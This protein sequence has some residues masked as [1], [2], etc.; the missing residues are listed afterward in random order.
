MYYED[1]SDPKAEGW[2]R[3]AGSL[4]PVFTGERRDLNYHGWLKLT[5]F[6]PSQFTDRALVAFQPGISLSRCVVAGEGNSSCQK[7]QCGTPPFDER[8]CRPNH[9]PIAETC[10]FKTR[11][12]FFT[13]RG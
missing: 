12:K 8:N 4:T 11:T 6:E 5:G 1:R 13:G 9:I 7:A 10:P 3:L 2:E